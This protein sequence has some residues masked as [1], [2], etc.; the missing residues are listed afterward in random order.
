MRAR[1]LLVAVL[2]TVLGGLGLTAGPALAAAPETPEVSV[3]TP[4]S[5][6]F[7]TGIAPAPVISEEAVV[8]VASGSATFQA[9]VS[10]EGSETTY[11]FEYGTS[12]AYGASVPLP[13]GSAG[14]GTSALA[15]QAHTQTLQAHT[16]YHYRVIATNAAG[17]T[18]GPDQSFTT[19]TVGGALTLS[20]GRQWELVSPPVKDGAR[21][22]PADQEGG[23]LAQAAEDGGAVT[24][25]A[26]AP[27]ETPAGN[28]NESQIFSVRGANGW[29]SRDIEPPHSEAIEAPIG[30]GQQYRF[31]SS[32]LSLG[33][34][35]PSVGKEG[36]EALLSPEATEYTVYL[37]NN[38]DDASAGFVPLVTAANVPPGTEFKGVAGD[39]FNSRVTFVAAAPDAS[40]IVVKARAALTSTPTEK[41]LYEWAAGRLQLISIL[42]DGTAAPG[43][44]LG[45]RGAISNDGSRLVWSSEVGLYLRD[46]AKGETLQLDAVQGGSGTEGAGPI[47]Q[48]ATG[49]GSRVFFTDTQRLTADATSKAFSP[50]LYECE[51]IEEAGR[52][53]CD[54]ADLT[55][56][57]HTGESADTGMVLGASEDGSYVYFMAAG[58]LAAGAAPSPCGCNLYVRHGGTTRFIAA[59]SPPTVE[60]YGPRALTA[61]V[62]PNGRYLTFM[63]DESLTGYD[64]RD[65][66]SGSADE[67]VYLYDAASNQLVCV[68]CNPIGSRPIGS[69]YVGSSYIPGSPGISVGPGIS[70]SDA[71]Y[72]PRYLSDSGRLFFDS[73]DSLI[74]QDTNGTVDVYEYEPPG[75]G[76]CDTASATFGEASGGCVGL[77]SSGSSVEESSFMDASA[78]GGD[79][80]FI[81]TAQLASQD[82]DNAYD[83]YDAHACSAAVPCTSPAVSPPP[84]TSADSCRVAP[85]LQPG[86]FGAPATA[87]FVG[88]GNAVAPAGGPVVKPKPKQKGKRKRKARSRRK[89]RGRRGKV[90]KSTATRS[91]S[92]RARRLRGRA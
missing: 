40:H 77:I 56:D 28:A 15:V 87:T 67:E 5:G 41:G 64:N 79:V 55:V 47:F 32:D 62:S 37:H 68:S 16:T 89:Q 78:D 82:F 48:L 7:T 18:D 65:A 80:F 8:N 83:V 34:L 57:E 63:S 30:R 86:A 69:S 50:D 59:I 3:Q 36:L 66:S 4:V 53:I 91:L 58:A 35:Q 11:R 25:L 46:V 60:Q 42:P 61:R 71:R 31:F 20:D 6:T 76:D 73:A 27:I 75:V 10:P 26:N 14:A 24:Y 19:Q 92:A 81:T 9:L 45:L 72:Q 29:S 13:D 38:A 43:P 21:I 51:I 90:G 85:S 52:L 39:A 88:V 1:G 23:G 17:T 49:D 54:L 44:E 12:D 74:A 70:L 84:C 33:I 2:C 22:M